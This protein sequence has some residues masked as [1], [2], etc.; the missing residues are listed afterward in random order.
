VN[1]ALAPLRVAFLTQPH[2]LEALWPAWEALHATHSDAPLFATPDW[3][4][5]W[6]RAFG[7][8]K[9]PYVLAAFDGDRL[10]GVLPLVRAR[11]RLGLRLVHAHAVQAEDRRFVRGRGPALLPALQLAPLANL[12]SGCARSSWLVEPSHEESAWRAWLAALATRRDWHLLLLPRARE[13]TLPCIEAA[14]RSAG[15]ALRA[16]ETPAALFDLPPRPWPEYFAARSRHFRKRYKVAERDFAKLGAWR[17]DAITDPAGLAAGFDDLLRLARTSWKQAGRADQA[18]HVPMT[19]EAGAFFRDLAQ[20]AAPRG[21]TVLL[22]LRLDGRDVAVMLCFRSGRSLVLLQTFFDPAVARA[23]PGRLLMRA[24]IGWGAAHGI[25]RIDTNGN[26]P[27]VRMFADAPVAYRSLLGFAGGPWP[28]AL[29][30][31]AAAGD[32]LATRAGRRA[33]VDSPS[34][35]AGEIDDE[36]R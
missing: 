7:A 13:A 11:V 35:E 6:L 34:G 3:C 36:S 28:R 24:A 9:S 19:P 18:M 23:S 14:A 12:P 25:E 32:A 15:L 20:A 10:A 8:G 30:A 16:A 1:G 5:A 31:L 33:A 2:E 26:S 17:V 22:A 4:R 21:D 27:L 29:R